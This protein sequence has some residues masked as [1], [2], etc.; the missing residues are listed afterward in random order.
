[1]TDRSWIYVKE[2]GQDKR[3]RAPGKWRAG[4][5]GMSRDHDPSISSYTKALAAGIEAEAAYRAQNQREHDEAA[6]AAR[7]ARS[8]TISQLRAAVADGVLTWE[9]CPEWARFDEWEPRPAAAPAP[10]PIRYS[11]HVAR[12]LGV[13]QNRKL[14]AMQERAQERE[15]SIGL[16]LGRLGARWGA[17]VRIRTK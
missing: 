7:V 4:A 1:M 5:G 17:K 3:D 2:Y 16:A 10:A 8:T 14:T 13:I 6:R 15:R 12:R 11:T 9:Q